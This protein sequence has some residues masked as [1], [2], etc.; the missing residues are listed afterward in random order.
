MYCLDIVKNILNIRII[1]NDKPILKSIQIII[2]T[3]ISFLVMQKSIA[4]EITMFSGIWGT[5]YYQDEDK[6]KKKDVRNLMDEHELTK[7]YWNTARLH[8]HLSAIS[9]GISV[10]FFA[11]HSSERDRFVLS[12]RNR[13]KSLSLVSA[14][15]S[16]AVTIGFSFSANTLRKKAILSYNKIHTDDKLI[17]HIGQTRNGIGIVFTF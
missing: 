3:F 16:F 2:L 10:A 5:K 7:L 6:I 1:F 8:N 12:G 4:Q 17:Y 13:Y 14:A 11:W 15:A 9:S